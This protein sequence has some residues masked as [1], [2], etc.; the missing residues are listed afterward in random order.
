MTLG[1][2]ARRLLGI[3][4]GLLYCY[5]A[6]SWDSQVEHEPY[7]CDE[8]LAQLPSISIVTP[9]FNQAA[10]LAATL[11]S[12]LDQNY[13]KI[14]L[15]VQDAN[16]Q[17]GSAQVLEGFARR[18]ADIQVQADAGQAQGINRGLKRTTGD[19]LAY[20]NSDDLLLPGTLLTIGRFFKNNKD[21]DVVYGD[22]L[23]IDSA[24]FEIGRWELPYH[25][26][27]VLRLVDYLP[28]ETMFW[29]RSIF[30][31]IGAELN[32]DFQFALDWDLILRFLDAGGKMAHIPKI[33]GAFRVHA[34]QKTS[35]LFRSKGIQEIAILRNRT[36]RSIGQHI[37]AR[38]RLWQFLAAHWWIVHVKDRRSVSLK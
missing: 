12:V 1:T 15:V 20:L 35:A 37:A 13:P 19:I 36:P 34:E 16:S 26:P 7:A 32:E 30:D 14:Q 6:R 25:D 9:S 10:F 28:Q 5:P 33:L 11:N 22:R 21:V 18:G 29:R 24:G 2:L 8:E 3:R 31:K 38:L 4:L 23:I 27:T 17:D